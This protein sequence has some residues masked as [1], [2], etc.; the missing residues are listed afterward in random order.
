[1][2]ISDQQALSAFRAQIDDLDRE[3]VAL[4]AR[5]AA[6]VAR[7]VE[8]KHDDEAVRST[9]RVEQVIDRVR[10]L[11]VA[12]GLDPDIVEP[13]Y[14]ALITAL[15]EFQHRHLAERAARGPAQAP[16]GHRD[17]DL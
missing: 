15:T 8:V 13:T 10:A 3:I 5:R 12:Q 1:M 9:A 11:A 16:G 6:I 7:L 17:H 2:H 4:I 14:R